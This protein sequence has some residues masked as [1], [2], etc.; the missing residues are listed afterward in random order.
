MISSDIVNVSVIDGVV[1]SGD[2]NEMRRWWGVLVGFYKLIIS[3]GLV[4]IIFP[5]WDEYK[6]EMINN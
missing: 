1:K 3:G 4:I 2:V 6:S 5:R